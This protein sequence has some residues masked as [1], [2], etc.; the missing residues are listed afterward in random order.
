MSNGV[1]GY[2]HKQLWLVVGVGFS[3]ENKSRVDVEKWV[4]QVGNGP[5]MEVKKNPFNVV[6]MLKILEQL[7]KEN[8]HVMHEELAKM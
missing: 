5:K 6:N 3:H 1:F 2:C 4:I 7:E 8:I